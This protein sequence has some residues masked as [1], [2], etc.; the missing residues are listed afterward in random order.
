MGARC[1]EAGSPRYP[2]SVSVECVTTIAICA[3][4]TAAFLRGRARP[5]SIAIS[6][7][8]F[9]YPDWDA[10]LPRISSPRARIGGNKFVAV[11]REVPE[12]SQTLPLNGTA[13]ASLAQRN[14]ATL[15]RPTIMSNRA[16]RRLPT[17]FKYR[18]AL[19]CSQ[20]LASNSGFESVVRKW[21]LPQGHSG[22]R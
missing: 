18:H 20:I 17:R 6:A 14:T 22:S 9:P 13:G 19:V 2:E 3:F 5:M 15:N 10:S 12:S 8:C 4:E 1:L 21:R 16:A 11:R 7:Y